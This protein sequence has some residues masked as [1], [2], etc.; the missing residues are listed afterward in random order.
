MNGLKCI[1]GTNLLES[2]S[3]LLDRASQRHQR[4]I[5]AHCTCR[6]RSHFHHH[7][8]RRASVHIHTQMCRFWLLASCKPRRFMHACKL[9]GLNAVSDC[10]KKWRRV[11]VFGL[12]RPSCLVSATPIRTPTTRL[13]HLK[14]RAFGVCNQMPQTRQMEFRTAR[15]AKSEK[16]RFAG[17]GPDSGAAPPAPSTACTRESNGGGVGRV[18]RVGSDLGFGSSAYISPWKNVVEILENFPLF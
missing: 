10:R 1:V 9:C 7:W 5:L 18:R 6:T 3:V 14:P 2:P 13:A 12:Q 16:R 11:A 17:I 15:R 4:R 8:G